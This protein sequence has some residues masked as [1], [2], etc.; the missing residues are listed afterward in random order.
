M[1]SKSD[2]RWKAYD[3]K[4]TSSQVRFLVILAAYS[5]TL[6]MIKYSHRKTQRP[7]K[8]TFTFG[9]GACGAGGKQTGTQN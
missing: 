5:K 9:R 8:P 6:K 7:Q 4:M 1:L 2:E 3:L